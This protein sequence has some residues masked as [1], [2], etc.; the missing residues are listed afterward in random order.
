LSTE[1]FLQER[2]ERDIQIFTSNAKKLGAQVV[3]AKSSKEGE[4]Q[5]AEIMHLLKQDID[6]LLI[7]P[8][9]K[10]NLAEVIKKVRARNIPVVAYDRLIMDTPIDGFVSFDNNFVGRAMGTALVNIAPK[11][12]YIVINGS[13]HDQNSFHVNSGLKRILDPYI[14]NRSIEIVNEVWLKEWSYDEAYGELSKILQED[15]DVTAISCA[16]DM[17]AQA[18]IKVLSERRLAGKVYVVGQ[19]ADLMACQSIINGTQLMTVYKPIQNLASR[20]AEIAFSLGNKTIPEPDLYI[21]NNSGGYIPY[22]IEKPVPVYLENMEETV[23]KDGFH[24][25]K[26]IYNNR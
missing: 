26:D 22:F 23:I 6:V 2:W 16:N 11:G 24:S 10:N 21:N 8:R 19:D 20:A 18:A 14:E 1:V 5:E 4:N 15:S 12:K 17:I 9:D 25:Y 7:I 13:V 3:F